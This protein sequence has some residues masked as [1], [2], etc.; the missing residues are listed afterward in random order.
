MVSTPLVLKPYFETSKIPGRQFSQKDFH[1]LPGGCAWQCLET[2][3][4]VTTEGG[5]VL[6][7]SSGRPGMLP[8]ILRCTGHAPK[9]E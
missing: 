4:V 9:K 1:P 8:N 7:A 3:E 5:G 6:M 2:F